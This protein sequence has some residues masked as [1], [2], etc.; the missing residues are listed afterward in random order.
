MMDASPRVAAPSCSHWTQ[1][2]A[3]GNDPCTSL[4][5]L[6]RTLSP[7]NAAVVSE[8]LGTLPLHTRRRSLCEARERKFLYEF[9]IDMM[10]LAAIM[11]G[12]GNP[13]R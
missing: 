12:S 13:R 8:V 3:S 1:V 5:S 6:G 9:S 2:L 10:R 4:E 7:A 11:R